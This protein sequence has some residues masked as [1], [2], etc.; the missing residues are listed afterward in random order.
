MIPSLQKQGSKPVF[1]HNSDPK[2]TSKTTIALMQ[3]LR[4]KLRDWSSMSPDLNLI[5]H[6]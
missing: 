3:G 4:V 2:N 1:Q 5:E 6:I